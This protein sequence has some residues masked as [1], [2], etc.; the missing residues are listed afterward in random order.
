M[1]CSRGA[2]ILVVNPVAKRLN[3]LLEEIYV[4]IYIRASGRE[5]PLS[6][7]QLYYSLNYYNLLELAMV[8]RIE[9]S[10]FLYNTYPPEH[11]YP[12]KQVGSMSVLL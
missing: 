5:L 11:P 8:A 4:A 6:S 3:D 7:L 12:I 10:I 1:R 9:F 2:K